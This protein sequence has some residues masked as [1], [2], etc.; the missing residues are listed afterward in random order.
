VK[1]SVQKGDLI[2]DL[3]FFDMVRLLFGREVRIFRT[4][5]R[6]ERSYEVFNL[7]APDVAAARLAPDARDRAAQTGGARE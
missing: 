1:V 2:Y 7:S 5:V 4:V 6:Y 3:S